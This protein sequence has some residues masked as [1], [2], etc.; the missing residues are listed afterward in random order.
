MYTILNNKPSVECKIRVRNK[1]AAT[2]RRSI[3]TGYSLPNE[4]AGRYSFVVKKVRRSVGDG[5]VLPCSRRLVKGA[6]L[7]DYFEDAWRSAD[8]RG[9][10][11]FAPLSA[12]HTELTFCGANLHSAAALI[13]DTYYRSVL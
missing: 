6:Q 9:P 12:V 10:R 7:T 11:R 1:N 5:A 4:M 8:A 2:F 3:G 13:R